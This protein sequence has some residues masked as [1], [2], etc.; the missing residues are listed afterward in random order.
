MEYENFIDM[1]P[2]IILQ[3]LGNYPW[4]CSDVVSK[5]I[6]TI[7]WKIYWNN[8]P[9]TWQFEARFS[10]HTWTKVIYSNTLNAAVDMKLQL[11]LLS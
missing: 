9:V 3:L 6:S 5:K 11:S 4:L 1:V 2:D 7:I 10:L 8:F